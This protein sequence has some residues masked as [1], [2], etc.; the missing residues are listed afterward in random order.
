MTNQDAEWLT[1]REAAL[2]MGV[3]ELTIRR[4]IKDGRMAHRMVEGKYYVNR[5]AQAPPDPAVRTAR[6]P[7]QAQSHPER[8]SPERAIRQSERTI[9]LES[10]LPQYALL[11]EQA[12]KAAVLE[13]R[14]G[15]LSQECQTLRENIVSLAGRTGWLES[16]L[17]E[18]EQALKLL[19]DRKRKVSLWRRFFGATDT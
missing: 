6:G 5:H 17:E 9:S 4:R 7:R 12:G 10:V 8:I 13:Q 2:A 1:I 19:T 11:A 16:K 3:S 14:V 15:E 18:R